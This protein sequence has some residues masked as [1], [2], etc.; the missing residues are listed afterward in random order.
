MKRIYISLPITG[1]EDTYESRL[2][3]AVKTAESYARYMKYDKFEIITPKDVAY[4]VDDEISIPTYTDYLLACLEAI[5]D[6]D[7]VFVCD[8]WDES[9][10][11]QI[12]VHF[13]LKLGIE[14]VY[15]D[16]VK[17]YNLQK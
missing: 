9:K 5:V 17:K 1:H 16:L 14:V 7:E 3:E 15:E 4:K 6:C 11:C 10:G 8:G 12:E 2:Q 13:A